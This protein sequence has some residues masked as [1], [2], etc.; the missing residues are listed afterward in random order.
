[1]IAGLARDIR[2]GVRSLWRARPVALAIIASL[3][4]GI[5]AVTVVFS[6]AEGLILRPLPAVPQID[7]LLTIRSQATNGGVWTSRPEYLDWRAEAK[8]VSGLAA[9]SLYLF[10]VSTDEHATAQSLPVYGMFVSDNYFSVLGVR[11][12]IGR[13][14][15]DGDDAPGAELVAVLSDRFWRGQFRQRRDVVGRPI[16]INGRVVTI[17]GVATPGFGGTVAGAT[18]DLGLPLEARRTL[19]TADPDPIESR[20]TRWLDVIARKP[21]RT[22]IEQ[23]QNEFQAIGTAMAARFADNRGRTIGVRPLDTGSAQQLRPLFGSVIALTCITLVIICSNIAN[24]LLARATARTH[25]I[26]VRFAL[27][28]TRLRLFRQ[29]V[30]ENL[31]LAIGGGAA[32]M[33]V[34]AWSRTLLIGLLPDMTV[35]I[36]VQAPLDGRVLAIVAGLTIVTLLGFGVLP[37]IAASGVG[38]NAGF[39]GGTRVISAGR[40]RLRAMLVTAQLALC[41]TT[42]ASGTLFM[43]RAAYVQHLDPGFV[44]PGQVLLFQTASSMSGYTDLRSWQTTLDTL[45]ERVERLPGIQVASWAS[46]VPLGYAGY[47]RKEILVEGYV[48]QEGESMRVL[49]NSVAPRYFE[50]MGIPVLRGRPVIA[51]DTVD[52]PLVAVVNETLARRFWSTSSPLDRHVKIGALSLTVVGVVADGRYDYRTIDDPPAPLLYLAL[53]Q[54]PSVFVTLHARTANEPLAAASSVRDAISAVDPGITTLPPISLA[55][56]ISLPMTPSRAG[57]ILLGILGTVGLG[58]SALGLHGVIAYGVVLRR[59]EIAIRIALGATSRGILTIFLTQAVTLT[60]VGLSIGWACTMG[61]STLLG[62]FVDRLPA[63]DARSLVATSTLL[64]LVGVGAGFLPALRATHVDPTHTLKA[65]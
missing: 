17:I 14:L 9:V 24:L 40:G 61:L 46:F 3:G 11:A 57:V 33:V 2:D 8:S 27:G 56:Y 62:Y 39:A 52:R 60:L 36:D 31:L 23:V 21:P 54:I 22:S 37:A 4:L 25:E 16:R 30:V 41:L 50:L 20:S 53:R 44:V 51:D 1:M 26:G 7:D 13:T 64:F 49:V 5:G 42:L 10:G 18:F 29:L 38:V 15:R 58:L 28:A 59:R 48:P 55:E 6:L 12:A 19:T 32:G 65:E 43:R 34:G 47:V 45:M 35:P 63:V